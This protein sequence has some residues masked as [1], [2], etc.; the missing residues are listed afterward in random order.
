MSS[1]PYKVVKVLNNNVI[2]ALQ[3]DIEKILFGKGIGFKKSS[4][5]II[6]SNMGIDKVFSLE[7]K[8]NLSKFNQILTTVDSEFI[9]VCEEIICMIGSQFEEELDERIHVALTDHITFTIER[10]KKN[11]EITNPFLIETETLYKD[12]FKVAQKAMNILEAHTGIKIPDGEIGFIA[13]HIHTA[14]NKSRL[15]N[16][17]RYASLATSIVELI[18]HELD[19]RIDKNSL[20]YARFVIHLR[21]AIERVIKNNTIRNEL[22]GTIKRKYLS[23][24]KIA[25]KAGELIEKLFNIRIVQDEIGYIAMHIEKLKNASVI[26]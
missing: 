13:L 2:L 24:Y 23:S 25:I 8:E 21:F 15:S 18:E 22:L 17:I 4:G 3:G 16:T 14:R 1:Q 7:D 5:S 20:D 26:Y 6:D 10:L 19:I 12:E 11:E 9:G